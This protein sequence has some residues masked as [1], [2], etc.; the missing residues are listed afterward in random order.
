[1]LDGVDLAHVHE[2]G[3]L[4][5]VYEGSGPVIGGRLIP[6]TR[7]L[8]HARPGPSRIA[9]LDLDTGEMAVLSDLS[10]RPGLMSFVVAT[11]G[12]Q[13]WFLW[14]EERGDLWV[15]DVGTER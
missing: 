4:I 9:T 6:G 2:D 14:S 12:E 8:V 15:M 13:V 1:M 5:R 10:G 11:D 7:V 3:T